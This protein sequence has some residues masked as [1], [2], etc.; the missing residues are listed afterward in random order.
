VTLTRRQAA[1]LISAGALVAAAPPKIPGTLDPSPEVTVFEA[2][3]I[4]TMDRSLPSARFVATQGGL[5]LAVSQTL[6]ELAPW[7]DGRRVTLNRQF[8]DKVLLPGLIDPHVHPV[9]AAVM[10][11]L[12]FIAPDDWELPSG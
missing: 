3:K 11:N 4:I 9:Q 12:P 1:R 2:A 6:A 5:I 7:T 8:A 10:L